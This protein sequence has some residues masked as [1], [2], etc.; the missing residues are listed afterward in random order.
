MFEHSTDITCI[1]KHS[2]PLFHHTL[3]AHFP[4]KPN[5]FSTL[6]CLTPNPEPTA[7]LNELSSFCQ[8]EPKLLKI[9]TDIN[10]ISRKWNRKHYPHY[11]TLVHYS[12]SRR[13]RSDFPRNRAHYNIPAHGTVHC[14]RHL[15]SFWVLG[16]LRWRS[17]GRTVS[18][19]RLAKAVGVFECP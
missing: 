1:T 6:P 18:S 2:L 15:F 11:S 19:E 9:I 3:A 7:K 16:A 4:P 8:D 5:T 10:S 17:C 13:N 14:L 12:K